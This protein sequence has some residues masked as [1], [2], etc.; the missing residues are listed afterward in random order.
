MDALNVYAVQDEILNGVVEKEA[1][2]FFQ[3]TRTAEETARALQGRV[4]LF[5][6][7]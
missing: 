2:L 5:L 3:G 6:D 1:A 4:Q 7:E